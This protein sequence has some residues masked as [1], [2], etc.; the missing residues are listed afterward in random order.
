MH[1][2]MNIVLESPQLFQNGEFLSE[3]EQ[4]ITKNQGWTKHEP[5]KILKEKSN[6]ILFKKLPRIS[7]VI[8]KLTHIVDRNDIS[9]LLTRY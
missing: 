5:F 3:I 1:L 4:N 8:S 6:G 2:L 9:F 7:L